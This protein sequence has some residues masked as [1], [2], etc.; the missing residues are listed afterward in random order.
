MKKLLFDTSIW[1]DFIRGIST[2]K[3][4][5]LHSYLVVDRD[6]FINPTVYQEVLQGCKQKSQ[7]D[8]VN[9][10]LNALNLL[11][12]NNYEAAYGAANIYQNLRSKGITIRKP[13]DCLIAYYALYFNCELV[14]N[15]SDFDLIAQ[16][17]PL[18]LF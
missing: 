10:L 6:V 18:I 11:E 13:N 8:R 14:Q 4:E 2:P 12:I 16:E 17:Y 5:L 15:D 7:F 3:S 1:V 9:E